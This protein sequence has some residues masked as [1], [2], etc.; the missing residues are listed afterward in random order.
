MGGFT[1]QKSQ[2]AVFCLVTQWGGAMCEK[3]KMAAWKTTSN[4]NG[5]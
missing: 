5:K 2:A 3:T 1:P 4:A